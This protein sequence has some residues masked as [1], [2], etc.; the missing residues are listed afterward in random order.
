M[1]TMIKVNQN[2]PRPEDY[3]S[4]TGIPEALRALKKDQSLSLDPKTAG[5]PLAVIRSR[6]NTMIYR[7][8]LEGLRFTMKTQRDRTL[9]IYPVIVDVPKKP[10][11]KGKKK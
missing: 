9:K 7:L 2:D 3:P 4:L 8:R 1:P 5:I 10:P 6:L 11:A